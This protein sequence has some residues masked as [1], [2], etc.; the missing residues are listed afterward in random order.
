MREILGKLKGSQELCSM[1]ADGDDLEKFAVGFVT[2]FDDDFVLFERVSPE[3][4]NDGIKCELIDRVVKIGVSDKYTAQIEKLHQHHKQK[5]HKKVDCTDGVVVG[6]LRYAMNNAVICAV[7]L[8]E[9]DSYEA[10]GFVKGID[11]DIVTITSIDKHGDDDGE[12]IFDIGRISHVLCGSS[13]EIAL[14]ILH[15]MRKGGDF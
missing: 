13:D 10:T 8:C 14:K 11:G 3:G 1:Y 15:W 9:S 4:K 12:V 2:D 5:R 7:E 6:I